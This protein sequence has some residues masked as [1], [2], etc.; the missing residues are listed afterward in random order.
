MYKVS[1]TYPSSRLRNTT[2]NEVFADDSSIWEKANKQLVIYTKLY[3]EHGKKITNL[4]F[5]K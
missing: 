4:I 3:V 1:S 5:H 2:S